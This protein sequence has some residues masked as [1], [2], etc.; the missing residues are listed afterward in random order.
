[1]KR[2]LKG[3]KT[4]STISSS[5]SSYSSSSSGQA[6]TSIAAVDPFQPKIVEWQS[7]GKPVIAVKKEGGEQR[8]GSTYYV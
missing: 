3:Y 7:S 5:N 8:L 6:S 2:T 1:M 4:C